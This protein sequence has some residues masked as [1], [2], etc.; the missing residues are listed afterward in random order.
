MNKG[1]L[2][3]TIYPADSSKKKLNRTLNGVYRKKQLQNI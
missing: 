2:S 3:Q 1:T